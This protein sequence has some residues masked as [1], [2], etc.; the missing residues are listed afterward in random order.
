LS[1]LSFQREAGPPSLVVLSHPRPCLRCSAALPGV[2]CPLLLVSPISW[3]SR[4]SYGPRAVLRP[5]QAPPPSLW[6]DPSSELRLPL[7]PLLSRGR[8]S[9]P[10]ADLVVAHV[11]LEHVSD[12][13]HH[14][15]LVDRSGRDLGR[16]LGASPRTS[17]GWCTAR[18]RCAR[19]NPPPGWPPP[20][21]PAC[22]WGRH[23]QPP[24]GRRYHRQPRSSWSSS[25]C[26]SASSR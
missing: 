11:V 24:P 2:H 19:I 6:R 15:H 9:G 17:L 12:R 10:W 13:H 21:S 7:L 14:S 18:S 26:G 4:V 5:S 16:I 1:D 22:W 8:A 23:S 25:T 20:P 3:A